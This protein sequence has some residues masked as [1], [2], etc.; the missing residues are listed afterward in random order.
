MIPP[1]GAA[2]PPVKTS[3]SCCAA[4]GTLFCDVVV[5]GTHT[6]VFAVGIIAQF[7]VD[8]FILSWWT[9]FCVV[10]GFVHCM[11]GCEAT[12]AVRAIHISSRRK[13]HLPV[14]CLVKACSQKN[15]K[16]CFQ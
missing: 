11:H 9:L 2:A 4:A 1:P 3:V 8:L 15:E 6:L 14:Y 5:V 13:N 12:E 16:G 7:C 10:V